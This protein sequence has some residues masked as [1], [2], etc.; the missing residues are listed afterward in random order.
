MPHPNATI[1]KEADLGDFRPTNFETQF[2]SQVLWCLVPR[3]GPQV[4]SG[5]VRW[6][7]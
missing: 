6:A 2:Q 1:E 3:L 4:D 5:Y 7:C